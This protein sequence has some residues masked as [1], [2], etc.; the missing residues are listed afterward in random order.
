MLFLFITASPD[1]VQ[2]GTDIAFT[3][4]CGEGY[5]VKKVTVT[6][7]STTVDITDTVDTNG[8]YHYIPND[9]TNI[10]VKATSQAT[11]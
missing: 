8:K 5:E 11:G 9:N 1:Y 2:A 7:N 6:A 3:V 4:T 10:T